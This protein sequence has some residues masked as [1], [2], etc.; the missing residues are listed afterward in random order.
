MRW[1]CALAT[2]V[3]ASALLITVHGSGA[4]AD[5]NVWVSLNGDSQFAAASG[6][7]SYPPSISSDGNYVA[8][9]TLAAISSSAGGGE[10]SNVIRRDVGRSLSV[11]ISVA[12]DGTP[13]NASSYAPAMSADGS[14]VVFESLASNLVRVDSNNASDIFLRDLTASTTTLISA[15]PGGAAGDSASYR[16]SIS[17]DGAHIA[18]CSRAS[19]LAAG[20]QGNASDLLLWERA[21][22]T[23][24]RVTVAGTS[25]GPVD[26]CERTAIDGDGGVVAF[27]ALTGGRSNVYTYDRA[28]GTTTPLTP[29]A[30]GS[31]GMSGLAISADGTRVAFDSIATNLIANDSNRSRD[32]FLRDL[33]ANSTSRVSVRSDGSQLPADSGASGVGLSGDGRFAVFG[34]T[35]P[36]VVPGD[37]SGRENVFRHDLTTGQTTIVS[38]SGFGGPENDSSY[39]PAVNSDGSVVAFT[40]LAANIVGG[41]GNRRPDVFLRGGGF[42]DNVGVSSGP[43]DTGAPPADSTPVTSTGGG[44][45]PTIALVGG[46]VAALLLLGGWFLL[47]RRGRA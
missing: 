20:G 9:Q 16:P 42:P 39:A 11:N 26:G 13:A 34:S 23:L 47:G 37:S 19:N 7:Y 3:A 29:G 32:L 33:A 43:E 41:D 22:G 38:V 5:G 14:L 30:D 25:N 17:A 12:S 28:S 31:S 21:T 2:A 36:D 15:A 44:G 6:A 27:S 1:L 24:T 35:A 46:G 10:V 4:A 8:Y 45:V 18:F 40:S